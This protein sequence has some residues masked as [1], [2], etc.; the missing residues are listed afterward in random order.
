MT[1]AMCPVCWTKTK[2]KDGRKAVFFNSPYGFYDNPG[3]R[4]GFVLPLLCQHQQ[5]LAQ[6]GLGLRVHK[7]AALAPLVIFQRLAVVVLFPLINF[8]GGDAVTEHLDDVLEGHLHRL[9]LVGHV[10]VVGP[11]FVVV[12]VA[13]LV[14]QPGQGIAPDDAF[15]VVGAA[16]ALIESGGVPELHR[17]VFGQVMS[18]ALPADAGLEAVADDRVAV[19]GDGAKMLPGLHGVRSFSVVLGIL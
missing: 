3:S 8:T 6:K 5:Q 11:V 9:H 14:V 19:F 16:V 10:A 4:R 15:L 12:A 2:R 13:A 1:W 17:A 7:V 18:Q